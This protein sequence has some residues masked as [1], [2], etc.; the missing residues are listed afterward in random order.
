MQLETAQKAF[1]TVKDLCE[2]LSI[3]SLTSIVK[4]IAHSDI[5]E[6]NAWRM[7]DNHLLAFKATSSTTAFPMTI[8]TV[9][10]AITIA[11]KHIEQMPEEVITPAAALAIKTGAT[12]GEADD[13]AT[14]AEAL[15]AEISAEQSALAEKQRA[16]VLIT[17][18]TAA[19]GYTQRGGRGGCGSRGRGCGRGGRGGRG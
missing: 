17:T 3:C 14:T 8:R 6:A 2:H 5:T 13:D 18:G 4:D 1:T 11:Q 12:K 15:A 10:T 7:A 16:L 19:Q 9:T